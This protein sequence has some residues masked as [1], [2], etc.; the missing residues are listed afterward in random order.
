LPNSKASTMIV[1]LPAAAWR[2]Q[3]FFGGLYRKVVIAR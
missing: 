1:T 2:K 3:C